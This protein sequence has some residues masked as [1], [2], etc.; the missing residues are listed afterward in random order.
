MSLD[1]I[2]KWIDYLTGATA[3]V[4]DQLQSFSHHLAQ[5]VVEQILC[6]DV[7]EFVKGATLPPNLSFFDLSDKV[8]VYV[9]ILNEKAYSAFQIDEHVL[10]LLSMD[11]N[12]R[13]WSIV[14][15][16]NST[17]RCMIF[18]TKTE[19]D[20]LEFPASIKLHN[21]IVKRDALCE[22]QYEILLLVLVAYADI[23]NYE[24]EIP[25]QPHIDVWAMT[26]ALLGFLKCEGGQIIRVPLR[27]TLAYATLHRGVWSQVQ[28]V[29]KDHTQ[30]LLANQD[31]A[32]TGELV[33]PEEPCTDKSDNSQTI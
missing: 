10:S 13:M 17:C 21:L 6:G 22:M 25:Q 12:H 9:D 28:R 20:S 26:F 3:C 5:S 27:R 33:T 7:I 19:R 16:R 18:F 15:A 23:R 8:V 11:E 14:R 1:F 24:I 32:A 29:L 4:G 30:R 2:V 31:C